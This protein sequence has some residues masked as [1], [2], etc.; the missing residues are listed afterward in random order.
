MLPGEVSRV[1]SI[2]PEPSAVPATLAMPKSSTLTK[3]RPTGV[4]A[5]EEI[6]RLDVAMD[7][8]QAMG[9]AEGFERLPADLDGPLRLEPSLAAEAVPTTLRLREIP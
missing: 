7:H 3:S 1:V 2:S 6:V 8:A 4:A 5:D 9:L